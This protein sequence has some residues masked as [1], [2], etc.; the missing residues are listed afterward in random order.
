[1]SARDFATPDSD[2]SKYLNKR[3]G[4]IPTEARCQ[5]PAGSRLK[6]SKGGDP[7]T[8]L[9]DKT[10]NPCRWGFPEPQA[11]VLD[12]DKVEIEL[13][14][15]RIGWDSIQDALM[16]DKDRQAVKTPIDISIQTL[17]GALEG[18]TLALGLL[19]ILER[20]LNEKETR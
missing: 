4:D 15:T 5:L 3:W 20:E 6:P 18:N 7:L 11:D 9:W 17:R 2:L 10:V 12:D 14:L 16:L 19:E 1:M 13:I 8:L